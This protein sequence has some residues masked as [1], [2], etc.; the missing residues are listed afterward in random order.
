MTHVKTSISQ[1]LI[2]HF[3]LL[4]LFC[5]AAFAVTIAQGSEYSDLVQLHGPVAYWRLGESSGTTASDVTGAHNGTYQN[6]VTLNSTGAI[7]GDTNTAA[8]FGGGANDRVQVTGFGVAGTGLTVLAWFTADSFGDDHF[9]S[10]TNGTGLSNFYWTLG[11]GSSTEIKTH[12]K[13]NGTTYEFKPSVSTMSAGVWYFI[14]LTYDGSTIRVYRNGAQVGSMSQSGTLTTDTSVAVALGNLPSGA[15]DRAFDGVLDEPAVFDKALT[16]AEISALYNAGVGPIGHWKLV[17]TSGTTATDSSK[18]LNHGTYTNGPVLASAG[19]YPGSG[20]KAANV[21]GSN[22]HVVIGNE[23]V[24]D[25]TGPMSVAAWIKVDVFDDNEQAIVT[26]GNNAWRLQ[27]YGSTNYAEFYCNSLTTTSVV[28]SADVNDGKWHHVVGV[29]TGSQLQIYVDGVLSNS[30]AATGNI[31]TNNRAL[32]IGSND[33][34]SARYFDG[35]IHDVRIYGYGLSASDVAKL[36]GFVGHWKLNQTSGASVTDSSL[37]ATNGAVNGTTNWSTDCAG[38]K[39]LDFDGSSNYVSV[40]NATHL[41]PTA[42]IT[43]AAWIEGDTWG[44]GGSVDAIM[45]KGEADPNNF[46]LAVADGKVALYLDDSDTVGIRGNTVLAAGQWY[47]V[48]AVWNGATVKIF[49]NGVLDNTPAARTGTIGADTRALYIGGHPGADQFDGMIRDVRLYNRAINDA[50]VQKLA[51]TLG[52]WKFSEGSG[53]T[54]ADTSGQSNNATLSGGA[55]WTTSCAG[56]KALATNGVGGIAQTASAFTP[57]DDGTVA[58][59]MQSN[60]SPASTAQIFGAGGDW[61]V[62][63]LTDGTLAFDL[64][65]D[66]STDAV[67]TIFLDEVGRWYHIAATFDSSDDTYAIYVDGQLE[68]SGS[69]SAAM[70]QQPAAILS[71][72][73]STGSPEY[74]QGALRDFRVYGRKLCPTEIAEIYGLV[75][76]WKLDETSSAVAADSSGFGRD[77]TVVGTP[78]WTVGTMGNCLEL[79]GTNRA[80]VVSLLGSPK[81]ITLAGWADLTAADSNGAELISLGDYFAIRLDEGGSSRAVFYEGSSWGSCSV[82]QTFANTGWHHIAAVFN[83][84]QNTCKLYVDGVEAASV[85]TTVTIP[86]GALG[87]KTVIGAHGNSG[88][89]RDFTGKLDDIRVYNRALCASE[90]QTLHNGAASEGVK[91]IKWVELQ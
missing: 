34:G 74:W 17:E 58:F 14:A 82:S 85:S 15:G 72:G 23:S 54:A 27:R 61:E 12:L 75:G 35:S 4:V 79:N 76:H 91:I 66:A 84:D 24:Y 19:P 41:Q 49:V 13:I 26:K 87:T 6:S 47:H 39:V 8:N 89:T 45:R 20:D 80:E 65:G 56:D 46:Q 81:N 32:R 88:T 63:Q 16:S 7:Y 33:Q 83:D 25:L 71:F 3:V 73:T 40:P 86:Y 42:A 44:A 11:L 90:I 59:W 62:R 70:S 48:A 37:A 60:G 2:R 22:D 53:T 21:D 68:K 30:V 18:N 5:T 36:Y 52:Y 78:N 64:C 43:I 28:S 10:K 69:N 77:M 50:D 51:G 9:V 29:Y 67:T 57:P 55:T 1:K 38:T 31:Q